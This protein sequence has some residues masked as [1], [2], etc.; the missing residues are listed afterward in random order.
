[1]KK[2]KKQDAATPL[3]TVYGINNCEQILTS[4][5][6]RI[7]HVDLMKE[8]T[9]WKRTKL[10][11]LAK[12]GGKA[13]IYGKPDFLKRYAGMRTQGIVVHFDGRNLIHD[14]LPDFSNSPEKDICLLFADNVEDPQNLGQIIRTAECA[15]IQGLVIPRHHSA[16]ITSTVL[17][18]SQGAFL[19]LP[20]Y[21]VGNIRNVLLKLKKEGFWTVAVE[22]G[23]MAKP[24]YEPDYTGKIA[25][26]VG[27]E[28]K[29]I[30]DLVVKTCDIKAT[31]PMHGK[32]GSL[33][34]SAAVSAII[35]ER[36]RQVLVSEERKK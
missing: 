30:R 7:H 15:G 36:N 3:F 32:T 35:F 1:L 16:G 27:S 24:W 17:Q 34:V 13:R 11:N 18:V 21:V 4:K 28:G 23:I 25:F 20:L 22:N 6:V 10:V 26:V 8:G 14:R 5:K 19:H 31:I 12:S 2:K 33:N 9:A 29:G